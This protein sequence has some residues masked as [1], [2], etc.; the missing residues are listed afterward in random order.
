MA[1]KRGNTK[2]PSGVRKRTP[3]S[4][5]CI[6]KPK[7]EKSYFEIIGSTNRRFITSDGSDVDLRFGVPKDAKKYFLQGK[8]WI[9]LK[10]G[11]EVLFQDLSKQEIHNLI[12]K[13]KRPKDRAILRL[14]LKDK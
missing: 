5:A 4:V 11:A 10:E 2:Q 6:E 12:A 3:E 8:N 14:A 1:K 9:G 7:T 13:C